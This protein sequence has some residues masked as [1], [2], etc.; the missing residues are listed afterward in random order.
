MTKASARI[1]DEDLTAYLDG[2]ADEQL[3][4]GIDRALETDPDLQNRIEALM[5]PMDVLR[6]AFA[7]DRLA[8]PEPPVLDLDGPATRQWAAPLR[9]VASVV[10][11][12]GVGI[13]GGYLLQPKQ[14]APGWIDVVASYQSLYMTETVEQTTQSPAM[15]NAVLE[16]FHS[17]S[18]VDLAAVTALEGLDFHRAQV[19]G[20]NNKPLMQMAY[21]GDEG[22]PFALCVINTANADSA[23]TD[24][25]AQGLAATSWTS[26]GV[27]YLVIGGQDPSR[28]RR[29]AEQMKT[30][31]E[32]G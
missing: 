14:A 31:L 4:R 27:G 24:R 23:L 16:Q 11:A 6:E 3:S 15:A 5:L 28:T 18:G 1:S 21:L 12:F 13:S 19:L 9:L 17:R 25:M 22:T 7:V 20:F 26:D 29:F 10:L 2:E 30:R 32:Q 8:A